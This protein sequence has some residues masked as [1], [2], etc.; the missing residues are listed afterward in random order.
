MKSGASLGVGDRLSPL[1]ADLENVVVDHAMVGRSV[2][3]SPVAGGDLEGLRGKTA[4]V[5]G[6]VLKF[7]QVVAYQVDV[8]KTLHIGT[9]KDFFVSRK[10]LEDI[11]APSATSVALKEALAHWLSSPRTYWGNSLAGLENFCFELA[12]VT[13][14][15]LVRLHKGSLE[16]VVQEPLG[17]FSVVSCRA[18]PHGS[19]WTWSVCVYQDRDQ[20]LVLPPRIHNHWARTFGWTHQAARLLMSVSDLDWG[21]GVLDLAKRARLTVNVLHPLMAKTFAQVLEVKEGSASEK[22]DI[23]Q[24][25]LRTVAAF[26]DVRLKANTIGLT[27]PPSDRRPYTVV[28]ISADSLSKARYLQQVVLHECIHIGVASTGGEPHNEEFLTMADKLGLDAKYRD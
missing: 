4:T 23:R 14:Q 10:V 24:T 22:A 15:A 19:T 5:T 27:E 3:V 17:D 9:L 28:S 8:E 13:P 12:S 21:D 11:E 7:G 6:V 18:I 20:N 25:C 1:E 16:F 26:S 2:E